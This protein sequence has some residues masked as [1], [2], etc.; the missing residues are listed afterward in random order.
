MGA[1]LWWERGYEGGFWGC[2]VM[3]GE[4][5]RIGEG[6]GRC[7]RPRGCCVLRCAC[8]GLAPRAPLFLVGGRWSARGWR[9][10]RA[11]D[12]GLCLVRNGGCRPAPP[13]KQS[14]GVPPQW[15]LMLGGAW[16]SS[17]LVDKQHGAR[18]EQARATPTPPTSFFFFLSFPARPHLPGH[19]VRA[20]P[21]CVLCLCCASGVVV[22]V[23]LM[24]TSGG[25]LQKGMG[26]YTGFL[27]GC[28]LFGFHFLR[29]YLCE[30]AVGARCGVGWVA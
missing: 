27:G 17:V 15:G 11:E 26:F 2:V 16:G 30:C 18:R 12:A 23:S 19:G 24:G 6:G 14:K 25:G 20:A 29:G 22:S 8:A 3:C 7:V 13:L 9:G 21:P 4:W 5:M 1:L 10:S 28:V